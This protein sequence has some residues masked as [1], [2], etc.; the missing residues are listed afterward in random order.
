MGKE[1]LQLVVGKELLRLVV[2]KELL[3]VVEGNKLMKGTRLVAGKSMPMV[4]VQAMLHMVGLM[5]HNSLVASVNWHLNSA[6]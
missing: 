2:G 1:L 3:R 5:G 4:L 6:L